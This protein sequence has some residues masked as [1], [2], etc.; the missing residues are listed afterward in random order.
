[1]WIWMRVRVRTIKTGSLPRVFGRESVSA[2]RK[3]EF[4]VELVFDLL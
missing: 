4:T 2:D 3:T 1:M